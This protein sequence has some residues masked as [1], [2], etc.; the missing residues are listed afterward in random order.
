MVPRTKAC[1]R[2]VNSLLRNVYSLLRN[3]YSPLPFS[4]FRSSLFGQVNNPQQDCMKSGKGVTF[5]A[6]HEYK[7]KYNLQTIIDY[8]PT[9]NHIFR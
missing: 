3:V 7:N 2:N 6:L 5:I 9:V 4:C 1:P 8:S